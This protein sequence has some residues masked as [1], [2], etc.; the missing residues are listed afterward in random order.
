[1]NF[2]MIATTGLI[3]MAGL[4]TACAND[5]VPT[6]DPNASTKITEDAAVTADQADCAY[7]EAD[8]LIARD[9]AKLTEHRVYS[10]EVVGAGAYKL[11]SLVSRPSAEDKAAALKLLVDIERRAQS[12]VRMA[13]VMK[14]LSLE[15]L[16][17]RRLTMVE[18]TRASLN[19]E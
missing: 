4:L 1:M 15:A 14:R 6:M 19:E 9:Q 12:Q 13:R 3:T 17:Q 16:A 8:E 10:M 2:R 7:R 11:W 18:S 5:P